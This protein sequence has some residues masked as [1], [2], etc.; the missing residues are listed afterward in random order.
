[1][2]YENPNIQYNVLNSAFDKVYGKA[3][4]GE[5]Q[6]YVSYYIEDGDYWKIDNITLGYTFNLANKNKF[7]RTIRVFT[8]M[9][10]I[11]TITGYKGLDP[12]VPISRSSG[13][14]FDE[15]DKTPTVRTYTFGV[16]FTF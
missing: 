6:E 12:E 7:V 13:I 2:Y 4:L 5:S 16:N 15:R 3:N 11:A 9:L 1:M 14:G 8:S 10:N